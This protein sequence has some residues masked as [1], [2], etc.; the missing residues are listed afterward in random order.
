MNNQNAAAIWN[1]VT[2]WTGAK[3]WKCPVCG[4]HWMGRETPENCPN[5][6]TGFNG[7]PDT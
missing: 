3:E 1:G 2:D 4:C 6:G 5:C 7:N